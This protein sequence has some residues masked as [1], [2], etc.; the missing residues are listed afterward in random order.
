M[1]VH[2]LKMREREREK[3]SARE[4][5]RGKRKRFKP[6]AVFWNDTSSVAERASKRT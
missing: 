4:R 3:G 2:P 5:E 6:Y 1:F